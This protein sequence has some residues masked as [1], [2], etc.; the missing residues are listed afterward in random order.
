MKYL[1]APILWLSST[2]KNDKLK[3][4]KLMGSFIIN[5]D[6]PS[7]FSDVFSACII[8]LTM[9]ITVAGA[10][11]SFSKLKLIKNYLRNTCE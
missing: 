3:T 11:R 4:I 10:E 7:S 2:L 8:F 6:L 5:N 1:G 9:L